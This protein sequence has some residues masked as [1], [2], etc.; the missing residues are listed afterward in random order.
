[1]IYRVLTIFVMLFLVACKGGETIP[2]AELDEMISFLEQ[3]TEKKVNKHL[4]GNYTV[5]DMKKVEISLFMKRDGLFDYVEFDNEVSEE[6]KETLITTMEAVQPIKEYFKYGWNDGL[7][8]LRISVHPLMSQATALD[9]AVTDAKNYIRK[10]ARSDRINKCEP[11]TVYKNGL[12]K[13]TPK[14]LVCV[15]D[16]YMPSMNKVYHVARESKPDLNGTIVFKFK[17]KGGG[18]LARIVTL[19]KQKPVLKQ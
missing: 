4:L 10:L 14:Q 11:Y 7:A 8:K 2:Q 6:Q 15:V 1:M 13:R 19:I 9:V 18:E 17:V 5:D 3:R 16:V 12:E